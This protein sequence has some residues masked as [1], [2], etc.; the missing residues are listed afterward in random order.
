VLWKSD[1]GCVNDLAMI[2]QEN[3]YLI[4]RWL[5]LWLGHLVAHILNRKAFQHDVAV[6]VLV[7]ILEPEMQHCCLNTKE[8]QHNYAVLIEARISIPYHLVQSYSSSTKIP[9]N[10]TI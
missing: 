5:S 10:P 3:D 7:Y 1:Q 8:V 2:I 9:S 6:R 4:I